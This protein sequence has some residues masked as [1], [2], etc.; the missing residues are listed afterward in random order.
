MLA[1]RALPFPISKGLKQKLTRQSLRHSAEGDLA[2]FLDDY[3][4]TGNAPDLLMQLEL[5]FGSRDENIMPSRDSFSKALF[6]AARGLSA[7]AFIARLAR[8][9]ARPGE[10]GVNLMSVHRSKGLEWPMVFVPGLE[11]YP[12]RGDTKEE[13]NLLFVALTRAKHC[14]VLSS[15]G[16]TPYLDREGAGAQEKGRRTALLL[17]QER[18][19]VHEALELAELVQALGIQRYLERYFERGSDLEHPDAGGAGR[20]RMEPQTVFAATSLGG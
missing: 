1:L 7:E 6:A 19:S 17:A 13:R 3:S 9:K 14:L 5:R 20:C 4:L 18:L 15:E 8:F 16:N 10:A 11:R 2:R 12:L